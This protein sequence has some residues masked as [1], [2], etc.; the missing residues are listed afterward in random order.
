MGGRAPHS[1]SFRTAHGV[2]GEQQ[3]LEIGGEGGGGAGAEG[4][5]ANHAKSTF[6]ATMSH[7]IRTPMNGVLGMVE[8]LERQ[9]LNEAQRRI[10]ATIR[11]SGQALQH[12][13]DDVLDIS[14]IEAG[15][16]EL[17]AT[18]FS[19]SGLLKATLDTFQPQVST[20]GLT[21]H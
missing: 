9:G 18:P 10:V 19:L 14:K 12:I 17:E 11:E 6:L 7:E 5:A 3:E 20:K 15:R 13:I 2:G 1:I 4:E 16:L 8:V 21:L